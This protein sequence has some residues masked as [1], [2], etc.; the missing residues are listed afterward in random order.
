MCNDC[1]FQT[2]VNGC[3]KNYQSI[4]GCEFFRPK[5][6]SSCFFYSSGECK[7]NI[8]LNHGDSCSHILV[9]QETH[10]YHL[11]SVDLCNLCVHIKGISEKD[12]QVRFDRDSSESANPSRGKILLFI[13]SILTGGIKD[14]IPLFFSHYLQTVEPF[15]YTGS[16]TCIDPVY[17]GCQAHIFE[18]PCGTQ[19]LQI[20]VIVRQQLI[21]VISFHLG[22]NTLA[23][24]QKL[25]TRNS[26][27]L[28]ALSPC[29]G[30][31]FGGTQ[32]D[33]ILFDCT[34]DRGVSTLD[35]AHFFKIYQN[36][37]EESINTILQYLDYIGTS[38][39]YI[40]KLSAQGALST[41]TIQSAEFT[42]NDLGIL[43]ANLTLLTL[44]DEPALQE[45]I[46]NRVKMLA[47]Q[48]NL[49]WLESVEKALAN[50]VK[51]YL[52]LKEED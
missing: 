51:P 13:D 19:S 39:V 27:T 1:I 38:R 28:V 52:P 34:D 22:V 8:K 10:K 31:W 44:V 41:G 50:K 26:I 30:L 15:M 17:T 25:Y 3:L 4:F 2:P 14:A 32:L 45:K 16:I 29:V 7:K 23:A 40:S 20:K 42:L 24:L 36:N 47:T 46:L 5:T 21:E 9:R 6:C 18:Y 49:A 11:D 43:H 35:A 33:D 48:E 12:V 37:L